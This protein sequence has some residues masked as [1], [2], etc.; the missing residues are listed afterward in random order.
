MTVLRI[1]IRTLSF[2]YLYI[3]ST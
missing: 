1:D 2:N 3:Y